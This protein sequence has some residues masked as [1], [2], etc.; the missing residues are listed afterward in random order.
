VL[1]LI[2]LLLL[3]IIT[4]I[5]TT[6]CFNQRINAKGKIDSFTI[7]MYLQYTLLSAGEKQFTN[8]YVNVQYKPTIQH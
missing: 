8:H 5:A 2:P 3:W 6:A 7:K 4:V 1:S